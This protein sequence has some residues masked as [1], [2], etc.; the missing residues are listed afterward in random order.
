MY[1]NNANKGKPFEDLISVA[2]EQYKRTGAAL[3]QKIATPVKVIR[4]FDPTTQRSK[5][6][7]AFYEAKSTVDFTGVVRGGKSIAFDAKSTMN[8]QLFNL[9]MI[10]DHQYDYLSMH[11]A[12]GGHSFLLVEFAMS[13]EIYRLEMS[14]LIVFQAENDRKSI[15]IGWFQRNCHRCEPDE[16][17]VYNPLDYLKRL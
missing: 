9:G 3:V 1:E 7:N 12:L 10:E 4:S 17:N 6:V 2:N 8:K 15:P 11:A 5:I 16:K 13:K 14:E